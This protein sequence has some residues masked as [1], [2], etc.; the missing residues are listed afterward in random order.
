MRACVFAVGLTLVASGT[1]FW[2]VSSAPTSPLLFA[3]LWVW[4]WEFAFA[5]RLLHRFKSYL[6]DPWGS[7]RRRPVL[8]TTLSVLGLIS[9]GGAYWGFLRLSSL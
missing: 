7:A 6:H 3:G 8:Y 2:V 9:A 5:R 1:V 4:S